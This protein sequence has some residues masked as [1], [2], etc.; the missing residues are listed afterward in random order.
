MIRQSNQAN[1]ATTPILV[2]DTPLVSILVRL[3]WV[4]IHA[5]YC[6]PSVAPFR[7]LR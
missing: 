2:R 4:G 1:S 7:R 5:Y 6:N 3:L